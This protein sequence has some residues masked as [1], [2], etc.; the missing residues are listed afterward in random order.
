MTPQ[1][2]T[3][4]RRVSRRHVLTALSGATIG[5]SGCLGGLLG[6]SSP[7]ITNTTIKPFKLVVKLREEA[8]VNQVSLIS[9]DGT[10]V[11]RQSVPAGQTTVSLP[12]VRTRNTDG[13]ASPLAPGTYEIVVANN[14]KTVAQQDIQL[15]ASWK[16]TDVQAKGGVS[17]EITVKNTGELPLKPTYL[18]LTDGVP[19]PAK[20]PQEGGYGSPNRVN[21]LN[22]TKLREY[23]GSG[24]HATFS[25][26]Q[27]GAF[28]FNT[29]PSKQNMP[30]WEYKAVKCQGL[31]HNAT[32][33]V[34]MA[35]TGTRT[36]SVPITYTGK[37]VREIALRKC[38]K[39][40]VGNAS[41]KSNR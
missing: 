41:R 5:L 37:P 21:T 2:T 30:Q 19:N 7:T 28:E 36:Y 38:S 31:T 32:L 35:P 17:V 16:L 8:T 1:D 33:T 14:D 27:N 24:K 26:S 29:N 22:R 3:P 20:S 15:K 40:T 9:K 23:L 39:I 18:A 11:S 12:T 4:K 34:K 10:T 6:L 25:P 13:L